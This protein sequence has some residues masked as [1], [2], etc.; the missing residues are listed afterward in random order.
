M[1]NQD[2]K[3]NKIEKTFQPY[4]TGRT[5]YYILFEIIQEKNM[6]DIINMTDMTD[7]TGM[8]A[9]LVWLAWLALTGNDW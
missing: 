4:A 5:D 6:I 3:Q 2:T 9:W 8:T 7:V 1:N